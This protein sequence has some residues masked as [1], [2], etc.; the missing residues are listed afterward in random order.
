MTILALCS[1]VVGFGFIGL[2]SWDFIHHVTN[3]QPHDALTGVVLA[4]GTGLAFPH[5]ARSAARASGR[6]LARRKP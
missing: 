5:H 4:L 3:L 2:G 1:R 6:W